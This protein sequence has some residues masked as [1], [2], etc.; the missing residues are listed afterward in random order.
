M[1]K[2]QEHSCSFCGQKSDGK[3]QF[4]KGMNDGVAICFN[5]LD[6]IKDIV[7][8]KKSESKTNNKS[9]NTSS[10]PK[11]IMTHLNDYIIGQDPA[12]RDLAIA[13][14]N[15]YKRIEINEEEGDDIIGKSNILL[16]GPT[17]SGKTLIAE[18]LAR[19]LGV[20]FAIADATTITEAGYVGEDAEHI[21][22][23]L[24]Q[25]AGGDVTK[26]EKGIIYLDEVDKIA[27][28]GENIST[29]RDVSGEGVQHALLKLIEGTIASVPALGTRNN[30]SASKT[31]I[32]TKNILFI[33]G[34]AFAGLDKI[35]EKRIQQNSGIG[36]SAELA[37]KEKNSIDKLFSQI[38]TEDLVKFGLVPEFIGRLPIHTVLHELDEK[39]LVSILTEP[40]NAITKQYIRLFKQDNIELVFT[41]EVLKDMAQEAIKKKT[42]A[43]GLRS[44]VE[45]RLNSVMFDRAD[46]V[47]GTVITIYKDK[48]DVNHDKKTDA[49][50]K[51]A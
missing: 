10:T 25:N 39:A 36:F 2:K 22:A 14:Y 4:I 42:G 34:G 19:K 49:I 26:A 21:I 11:E 3:L 38:E 27:K 47:N 28:K 30:P 13:V 41:E 6:D 16:I 46:Y 15:H 5:C 8:D 48:V 9:E 7:K 45:K 33:C 1:V 31:E 18:T 51:I 44:I 12:K 20:P 23:R 17:G 37:K 35:V 32:N 29:T 40:K 24:L 50:L 43:R